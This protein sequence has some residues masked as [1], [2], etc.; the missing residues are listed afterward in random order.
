MS[1]LPLLALQ[2]AYAIMPEPWLSIL[3]WTVAI[4]LAGFLLFGTIN[5]PFF[6]RPKK[7]KDKADESTQRTGV[8]DPP[9]KNQAE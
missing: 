9:D 4:I 3:A 6:R 7:T 8:S 5:V 1:I 2:R